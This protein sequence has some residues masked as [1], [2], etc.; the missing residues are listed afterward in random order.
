MR[1]KL[2]Q[3]LYFLLFPLSIL[4]RLVYR[5][6]RYLYV[7]GYYDS[8]K[9]KGRTI[10]IGNIA[11]GGSGKTPFLKWAIENLNNEM[12]ILV[13]SRGYRSNSESIGKTV[14]SGEQFEASEIGDENVEVLSKIKNGA[15]AVGKNRVKQVSEALLHSRY[16][17]IFLDDGFQ[18]LKINR[19]LN[20]VLF[21]SLMNVSQ[22]RVFPGGY[23]REGLGSL[24]EADIVVY[25]NC[26][27]RN[28]SRKEL[29]IRK[30]ISP[31]LSD[32]AWEFR[33]QTL[34]TKIESLN[35]VEEVEDWGDKSFILI[36]TIAAPEKF[37]I[38]VKESGIN[39]L[40]HIIFSDH[41]FFESKDYEKIEK[42]ADKYQAPILMTRKDAVK[43]D[44]SKIQA[45]S[46]CGDIDISFFGQEE[47]ILSIL[48]G[49]SC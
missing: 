3:V 20:I 25:T 16:D 37:S 38:L 42:I 34:L 12:K 33:S 8:V 36:S 17:I 35:R 40:E 14:L 49:E 18:H 9:F 27:G 41:H 28:A 32:A 44:C 24:F 47:K 4:V 48:K 43:F 2:I 11:L 30:R 46:Y 13:S 21:N 39:V 6:R 29:A 31:Y 19:D 1:N 15:L 23:L 45:Q 5:V 22:L 26:Q 10:S 7:I